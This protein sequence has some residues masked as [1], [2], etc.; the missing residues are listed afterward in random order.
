MAYYSR[1]VQYRKKVSG[2]Y[3]IRCRVIVSL[4]MGAYG[5]EKVKFP[6]INLGNGGRAEVNNKLGRLT[7]NLDIL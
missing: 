4:S 6:D 7:W 5:I 1:K 3:E 2:K